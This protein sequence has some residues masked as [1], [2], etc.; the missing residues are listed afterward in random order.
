MILFKILVEK[1][2]SREKILT[3]WEELFFADWIELRKDFFGLEGMRTVYVNFTI[4]DI[5]E[6]ETFVFFLI[7]EVEEEDA[8]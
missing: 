8:R 6:N 3:D 7:F 4:Y 2:K 1:S 5:Y